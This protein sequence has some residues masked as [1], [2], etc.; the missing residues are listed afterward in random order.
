[1]TNVYQ[2]NTMISRSSST[3]QNALLASVCLTVSQAAMCS[4]LWFRT[5]T[6]LRILLYLVHALKSS[7]GDLLQIINKPSGSRDENGGRFV[8]EG[9]KNHPILYL[10]SFP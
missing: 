3:Y 2:S 9:K 5:L 1:M 4:V 7:E 8:P 6:I 10:G